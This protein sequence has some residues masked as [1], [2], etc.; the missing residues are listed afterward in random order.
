[1]AAHAPA[2]F[3]FATVLSPWIRRALVAG[4]F[5]SGTPAA[6]VSEIAPVVPH[7]EGHRD[8]LATPRTPHAAPDDLEAVSGTHPLDGAPDAAES[9]DTLVPPDTPFFHFD[10]ADA[11]AVAELSNPN[12]GGRS[13]RTPSFGSVD[14]KR[15]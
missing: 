9:Y 8:G 1:V 13:S 3:H 5:G 15:S 7:R 4:G 11:V 14:V 6:R 12:V 10:L 2:Q